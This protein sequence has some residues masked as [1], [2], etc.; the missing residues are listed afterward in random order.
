MGCVQK[1]GKC[2]FFSYLIIEKILQEL[3]YLRYRQPKVHQSSTEMD[4]NLKQT[5]QTF[6]NFEQRI[7]LLFLILKIHFVLTLVEARIIS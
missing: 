7:G 5:I 2:L 3:Y 6:E 4:Y 1:L